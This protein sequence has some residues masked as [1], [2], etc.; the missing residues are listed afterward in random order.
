MSV[1]Y[2]FAELNN[3]DFKDWN[4]EDAEGYILTGYLTGGD[5]SSFKQAPYI[6]VHMHRTENGVELVNGEYVPLNESGCLMQSQWE[7]SDSAYSNKWSPEVQVYRY[8]RPV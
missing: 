7:W 6:T 3:E 1:T 4:T 2:S 5:A 8:N